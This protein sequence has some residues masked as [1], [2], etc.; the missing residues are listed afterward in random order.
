MID[1]QEDDWGFPVETLS[2]VLYPDV[3]QLIEDVNKPICP[4]LEMQHGVRRCKL[5]EALRLSSGPRRLSRETVLEPSQRQEWFQTDFKALDGRE[6]CFAILRLKHV[7]FA[8]NVLE[9]IE[10][11]STVSKKQ[12]DVLETI[13]REQVLR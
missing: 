10:H 9:Q 6:L 3:R 8:E 13:W 1:Y 12:R 2:N 11:G 7:P 5:G 4:P